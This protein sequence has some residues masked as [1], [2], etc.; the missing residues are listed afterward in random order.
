V[1]GEDSS[2][3]TVPVDKTKLKNLMLK[4]VVDGGLNL[5]VAAILFAISNPPRKNYLGGLLIYF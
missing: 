5:K 3:R 4:M 2:Y 1:R